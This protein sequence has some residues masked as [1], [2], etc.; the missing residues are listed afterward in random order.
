MLKKHKSMAGI[1]IASMFIALLVTGCQNNMTKSTAHFDYCYATKDEGIDLMLGNTEYYDGFSQNDLDYKMQKNDATMEEYQAFA[2]TQVEDFSKEDKAA[3]D[4]HMDSIEKTIAENEYHLPEIAQIT[5]IKTTQIEECGSGA[6]THG[7]QIYLGDDILKYL[8]SDQEQYSKYGEE[9]LWHEIFHCLTRCNPE[10]RESMYELIHFKVQEEDFK[11]PPSVFEYFISNPDVEHHNAYATFMIDGQPVDCFAALVTT[12]HFEEKGD[13]FF[14]YMTTGLVPIDGTDIY[15][16]PEDAS[17][18][19]EIFGKN[20]GYVIDPEE[21]MA[22]NF[23]YAMN[24]G[25]DGIN[26][27]AYPNPEIIEGIIDLVK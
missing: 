14:N 27:E 12:K 2:K 25:M 1:L 4:A 9:V 23:S 7:T 20:T 10:F 11:L 5:F 24:Y 17:N 8:A 13:S 19:Y 22:D 18:F 26:G 6:Y 3:I 16:T 15:Y 21:C